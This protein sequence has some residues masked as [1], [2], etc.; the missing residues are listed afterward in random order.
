MTYGDGD[1]GFCWVTRDVISLPSIR[2]DLRQ[3]RMIMIHD[4]N[5]KIMRFVIGK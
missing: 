3:H 2:M 5:V 4:A 1:G